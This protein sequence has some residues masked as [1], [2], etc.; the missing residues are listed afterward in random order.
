L[1]GKLVNSHSR[2]NAQKKNFPTSHV[3]FD[4]LNDQVGRLINDP[5]RLKVLKKASHTVFIFDV[6]K[7]PSGKPIKAQLTLKL[8]KK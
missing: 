8:W 4:I 5:F 6:S 7:D 1:L 2:L 3:M